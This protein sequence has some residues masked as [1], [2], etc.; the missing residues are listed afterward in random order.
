MRSVPF[1]M[2][3]L[4]TVWLLLPLFGTDRVRGDDQDTHM[5]CLRFPGH[6]PTLRLKRQPL[7]A[8]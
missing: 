1:P 8:A 2:I 3:L 4:R 6:P 7:L 5:L